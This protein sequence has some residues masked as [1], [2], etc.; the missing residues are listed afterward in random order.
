MLYVRNTE[1]LIKNR[2]FDPD[3]RTLRKHAND[4]VVMQD[5]VEVQVKGLAEQILAEDEK[6]RAQELVLFTIHLDFFLGVM[7]IKSIGRV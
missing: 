2:N 5:T 4:D 7:L 3:S 6:L 1:P